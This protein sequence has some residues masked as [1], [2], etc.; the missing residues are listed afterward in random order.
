MKR[1]DYLH[2]FSLFFE[3]GPQIAFVFHFSGLLLIPGVRNWYL[4]FEKQA[5]LFESGNSGNLPFFFSFVIYS[6]VCFKMVHDNYFNKEISAYKLKDIKWLKTL[7][8]TIFSL[9][10]IW[11]ITIFLAYLSL[12]YLA[13]CLKYTTTIL[14][15]GFAYWVGMSTYMRQTKMSIDDVVEYNKPSVKVYFSDNDVIKY[16]RRLVTLMEIEEIYLNPVLKLDFLADKLGIS[17]KSISR[18]L[19]Q[20]VGKN[21]NDFVNEYR[22]QEA[23]KKLTDPA[24]IRFTIASIAFDSGFNSLA[25][26]QRCFKQFTGIT[27]SQYQSNSKSTQ[28]PEKTLLKS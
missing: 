12:P 5:L 4:P 23:K 2:F 24:F 18:L 6:A 22:I 7:L 8:Y 3:M 10:I 13:D 27:P 11:S 9:I 16:Q 17:E 20:H 14:A 1:K 26:F 15:I 28:I 25:T 19:N 21:F